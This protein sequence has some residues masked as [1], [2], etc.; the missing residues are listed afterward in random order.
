MAL[1]SAPS[2]PSLAPSFT[3][4][5]ECAAIVM[6][7]PSPR[8]PRAS[9]TVIALPPRWTPSAPTC[10]ATSAFPLMRKSAF[11]QSAGIVAARSFSAKAAS[12]RPS[13]FRSRSCTA[14][15]P[16]GSDRVQAATTSRTRSSA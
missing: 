2:A 1:T 15:V 3:A 12:A 13:F 7:A 5:S 16:A 11:A 4:W 6:N 8:I 14:N 9:E 10:L